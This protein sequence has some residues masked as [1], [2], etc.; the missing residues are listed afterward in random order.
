MSPRRQKT[1]AERA[2]EQ[3]DTAARIADRLLVKRDA[4]QAE[5]ER[6]DREHAA[7]VRRRDYLANHPDLPKNTTPKENDHR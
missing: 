3:Y 1:P 4:A 5:Y 2:Q 7:A 6:L